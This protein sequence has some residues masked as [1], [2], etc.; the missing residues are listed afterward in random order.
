MRKKE[1][2]LVGNVSVFWISLAVFL[3]DENRTGQ[4]K[5]LTPE[6]RVIGEQNPPVAA[7][8][9]GPE[10]LAARPIPSGHFGVSGM[11]I[12]RGQPRLA[13]DIR[14]SVSQGYYAI[15]LH[16]ILVV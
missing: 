15:R 11:T 16:W 7:D 6:K 3:V 12:T 5:L 8:G 1:K 9:K 13:D 10:T 14:G 4:G 2:I